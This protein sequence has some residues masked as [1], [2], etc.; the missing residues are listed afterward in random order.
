MRPITAQEALI[1]SLEKLPAGSLRQGLNLVFSE[2]NWSKCNGE[3]KTSVE[4]DL[5][6]TPEHEVVELAEILKRLGYKTEALGHS[7]NITLNIFF[8]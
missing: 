4:L 2:I 6:I 7:N 3:L 8:V 1:G 5:D